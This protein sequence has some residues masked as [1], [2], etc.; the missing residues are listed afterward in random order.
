MVWDSKF[1]WYRG[2]RKHFLSISLSLSSNSLPSV[3][4]RKSHA[5]A[6]IY[7]FLIFLGFDFFR[8]IFSPFLFFA[9]QMNANDK[10]SRSKPRIL[11]AHNSLTQ[12]HPHNV[13]LTQSTSS[14]ITSLVASNETIANSDQAQ[15]RPKYAKT[16]RKKRHKRRR[17]WKT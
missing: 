8:W 11:I 3:S 9:D 12:A 5:W 15:R 1:C 13:N 7:K 14:S 10:F 2:E 6:L 4:K 17:K 16:S